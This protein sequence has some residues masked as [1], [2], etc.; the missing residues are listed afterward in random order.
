[1]L[2]ALSVL[3]RALAATY[4]IAGSSG[5]S[6]PRARIDGWFA[7]ARPVCN[8]LVVGLHSVSRAAG[9]FASTRPALIADVVRGAAEMRRIER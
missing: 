2:V 7:V 6:A 1:V 3:T 8:K 4:I 9:S 5:V